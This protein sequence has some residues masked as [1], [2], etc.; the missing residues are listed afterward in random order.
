MDAERQRIIQK[1]QKL[2]ALS[3][4]NNS[5]EEAA[6][7]AATAQSLLQKYNL[8]LHNIDLVQEGSSLCS[9]HIA[10]LQSAFTPS[11][12][13]LLLGGIQHGFDVE[14][15]SVSRMGRV[16][17]LFIG[18]EPDVSV[19]C[20]LFEY[21]YGF[22]NTHSLPNKSTKQKT[23]WRAGFAVAVGRRLVQNKRQAA[24]T[25]EQG[26]VLAKEAIA[27]QYIQDKFTNIRQGRG[28]TPM[29]ASLAFHQGVVVGQ[30]VSLARQV[31]GQREEA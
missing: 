25:Q 24:S 6:S 9:E 20:Q 28:I 11:W 12:V 15:L 1:I 5:L 26:L 19:A 17:L 30:S 27:K 23:E 18:V 3:Q 31:A 29:A 21:L 7:A 14:A 13:K 10:L 2:L 8:S 4:N 16:A 22:A